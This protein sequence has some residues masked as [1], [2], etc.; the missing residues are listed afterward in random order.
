VFHNFVTPE[1]VKIQGCQPLRKL[2]RIGRR[3]GEAKGFGVGLSKYMQMRHEGLDRFKIL[4]R[5]AAAQS[6]RARITVKIGDAIERLLSGL[7]RNRKSA[8]AAE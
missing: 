7:F 5:M 2:A 4:A 8:K 3:R 6:R 1:G